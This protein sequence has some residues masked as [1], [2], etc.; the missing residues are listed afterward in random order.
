MKAQRQSLNSPEVFQACVERIHALQ[1]DTQPKW[2][3]MS[4]AQMLAHCAEI[5]EVSEGKP[6]HDT[7]FMVRLLRGMIRRMVV[8]DKPYPRNSRTHPQYVQTEQRD[9]AAEKQRLLDAME[10]FRQKGP[11]SGSHPLFGTMTAEERGWAAYK[12]LDHHLQQFGV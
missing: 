8:G 9:F 11:T 7:P 10:A 1:A 5:A 12:H 4:A 2:G 6:L 3:K